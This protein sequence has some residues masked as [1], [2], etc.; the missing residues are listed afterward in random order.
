MEEGEDREFMG[1]LWMEKSSRLYMVTLAIILLT[2]LLHN[3]G[4][5]DD[6]VNVAL[7][8]LF[9]I[10]ISAVYWGMGPAVYAATLSVV[11]FDFFLF[12]PISVLR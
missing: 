7:V 10:L 8:Y 9:P 3:I 4:M 2:M 1:N 11:M 12:H 6:L 5:I